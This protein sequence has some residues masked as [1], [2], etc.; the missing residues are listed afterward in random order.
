[1]MTE[2]ENYLHFLRGE[3]VDHAPQFDF[4]WMV[5]PS[6]LY[7]DRNPD[8]SGFDFY[9]VEYEVSLDAGGGFIPI[10]G[11]FLL[12]DITRWRDVVKNPDL[13]DVDWETMAKNDLARFDRSQ[14]PVCAN[15]IPGFFQCLI[16]FMGF[17]EGLCAIY[18][19]P[20]ECKALMDY[21]GDFYCQV[22][23]KMVEY[24]KP[25]MM[26][27][28]DDV[29][30]ERAPFISKESYK[31]IFMPAIA[32]YTKVF[33]DAGIPVQMHNCG[34]VEDFIDLWV[35]AGITGWDP[36]QIS[37]DILGIHKKY[38]KNLA[39]IG[40]WDSS[41]V[42]ARLDVTDE[43]LVDEVHKWCDTYLSQGAFGFM[44]SVI[45]RFGDPEIMRKNEVIQ[46]E[47]L[48]YSKKFF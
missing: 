25:D 29:A 39:I 20:E 40:A 32:K 34:H 42:V 7:K 18:E 9:G 10:P 5:G 38:G 21:I 13:S 22:A 23:E 11:K 2:K 35:D 15:F 16:N 12:D 3:D 17:T 19:E 46:K 41:G 45:G 8:Q 33:T 27:L 43:M 36:A 30:T 47:F 48:E 6:V 31:E 37:N 1:M 26:W 44:G 28:P 4:M 14:V 24:Y